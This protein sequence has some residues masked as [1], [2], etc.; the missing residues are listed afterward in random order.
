MNEKQLAS[1]LLDK[2]ES[3]INKLLFLD[4]QKEL[5]DLLLSKIED[6][7]CIVSMPKLSGSL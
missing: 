7:Q 6:K 3:E 2:D 5:F 4:A 1:A